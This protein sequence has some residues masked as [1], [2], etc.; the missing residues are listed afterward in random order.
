MIKQ[1]GSNIELTSQTIED[2]LT[3]QTHMFMNMNMDQD[4]VME[5]LRNK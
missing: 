3:I 5:D 4:F 1:V 2:L